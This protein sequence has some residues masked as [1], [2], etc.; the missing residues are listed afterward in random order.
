MKIALVIMAFTIFIFSNISPAFDDV[1]ISIDCERYE[2]VIKQFA[3]INCGPLGNRADLTEQYKHIGIDFVRTHDVYFTDISNIF[4]DWDADANNEKNYNFSASDKIIEAII[5][6]DCCVFFRLGESASNNKSLRQPPK[7]FSKWAEICKHIVMHYNDG[8]ANGYHYNITYWEI[9]NEPDL[10][11]FWNGTAEDYYMLYEITAKKL[12]TYDPSLKIGGP[13]TS[14]VKNENFTSRF[15]EY[16]IENDIPLD[17][18]S[19]HM[20]T[21]SPYELYK[22]S[23][24][25]R[26]LLD[27]YGFSD[28]ENILTEWNIGILTPQ[29]DKDNAKNAA[30][31]ACCI[32]S[33]QN[34]LNHAFRYRGTGE[35]SWLMRLLGL[36]LSLFTYDGKY[37]TPALV[38]LAM[39]Y[40]MQTPI[41]LNTTPF[42]VSNGIAY[43]SGIS[44]DQ[45]NLSILIA[46][47]ESKDRKCIVKI[48]NIPWNRFNMAHYLIDDKHHFEIIENATY[49]NSNFNLKFSLKRNTI[50]FIR[51]TNSSIFPLEG[52]EVA[53]IPFILRLHCLDGITRLLAILLLYMLF[54]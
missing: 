34:T 32:I 41:K 44:K 33:F 50:H 38:Y 8:W 46:N 13:C 23:L 14:S 54:G 25:I 10:E 26:H 30:F 29:R 31:T 9:W 24:Y 4:P 18:F 53:K 51:L 36:D 1:V 40:M 3:E 52:P 19:W 6:A 20:Y 48:S 5:N 39:N 49:S 21:S 17:F 37:K 35:K 27:E 2:G 12:K 28:C 7:N 16:V 22:A 47:Y 43:L 11:G 45:K 15:L 42:N